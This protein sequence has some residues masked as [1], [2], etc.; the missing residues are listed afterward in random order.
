MRAITKKDLF[1]LTRLFKKAKIELPATEDPM[2]L[3]KALTIL[4]WNI[5]D[6]EK[7]IDKLLA[8]IHEIEVSEV[9]SMECEQYFKLLTDI[10]SDVGF[11]KISKA[12][13][14]FG[15]NQKS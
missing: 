3:G 13:S 12:L 5:G 1:Q 4:V 7:D 8:S 10:T 15:A 6:I 9:E 11:I 14:S 2:I